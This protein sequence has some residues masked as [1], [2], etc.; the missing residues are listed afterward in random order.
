MELRPEGMKAF[1]RTFGM[2]ALALCSLLTS[3]LIL[4]LL[5]RLVSKVLEGISTGALVIRDVL[6]LAAAAVVQ[7][8]LA[9]LGGYLLARFAQSVAFTIRAKCFWGYLYATFPEK[10]RQSK[11]SDG[12]SRL[13]VD[14]ATA[15][16]SM[17]SFV[18]TATSFVVVGS[19]AST[20]LLTM[21]GF[22]FGL[23][24][25]VSV[26]TST[27]SLGFRGF[28]SRGL[29]SVKALQAELLGDYAAVLASSPVALLGS[30]RRFSS[31]KLESKAQALAE[32]SIKLSGLTYLLSPLVSFVALAGQI[33]L[34]LVGAH[35]LSSGEL[36]FGG[37]V[38]VVLYYN[39]LMSALGSVP[40][41]WLNYLSFRTSRERLVGFG[42]E[43]FRFLLKVLDASRD[44]SSIASRDMSLAPGR[45]LLISGCS[46]S[47][48]STLVKQVLGMLPCDFP[49]LQIEESI[50]K[51][52][53]L[54]DPGGVFY[55]P[56]EPLLLA[57]SL[58]DE[59]AL[60]EEGGCAEDFGLACDALSFVGLAYRM[61]SP[62]FGSIGEFG[63]ELS[64]G[65][66]ARVIWVKAALSSAKIVFLDEPTS[67]LGLDGCELFLRFV[68][69][70]LRDRAV[71][72]TSHSECL[73]DASETIVVPVERLLRRPGK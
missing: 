58:V 14:V 28:L 37:F 24:V 63:S 17:L 67:A 43:G 44:D 41:L 72:I 25:G 30:V 4:V 39:L 13:I 57:S 11:A 49:F 33:V 35:R 51:E 12:A 45:L 40:T 3:S 71:I 38:E 53:S 21:D 19:V 61:D 56:Q 18:F 65:E 16:D 66:K 69:K 32:S 55:G 9:A 52:I 2:A 22:F 62:Y 23:A 8:V 20:A 46:G 47:G 10:G 6:F 42:V 15:V 64:E 29:L 34:F 27:L 54:S 60:S 5:P 59:L 1:F 48:K 26:L 68:A 73:I 50:R 36:Q 70:Y 7:L 31:V